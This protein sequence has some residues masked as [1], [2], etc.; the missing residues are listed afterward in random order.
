[1]APSGTP[2]SSPSSTPS[3]RS[4]RS[5]PASQVQLTR[6]AAVW[7]CRR[8]SS[9]ATAA[10]APRTTHSTPHT[11]S[12]PTRSETSTTAPRRVPSRWCRSASNRPRRS[13]CPSGGEPSSGQKGNGALEPTRSAASYPVSAQ[14]DSLTSAMRPSRPIVQKPSCGTRVCPLA[15]RAARRSR[16]RQRVAGASWRPPIAGR[17]RERVEHR[18]RPRSHGR[19]GAGASCRPHEWSDRSTLHPSC[20]FRCDARRHAPMRASGCGP[21]LATRGCPALRPHLSSE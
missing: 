6:R 9:S 18:V 17:G 21:A 3:S 11:P 1:M 4:M 5:E 20:D 16:P 15:C 2:L 12:G 14:S 10:A 13:S 7:A 8:R 19:S